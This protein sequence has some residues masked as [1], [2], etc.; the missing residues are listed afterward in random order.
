MRLFVIILSS[1]LALGGWVYW[2]RQERQRLPVV[3]RRLFAL[4]LLGVSVAILSYAVFVTKQDSL[5]DPWAIVDWAAP[6][7]WVSLASLICCACGRGK[8]RMLGSM[9]SVIILLL[10][11]LPGFAM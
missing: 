8:A 6:N 1:I 9:A 3:R 7:F 11:A 10:W 5:K 2:F 4:G